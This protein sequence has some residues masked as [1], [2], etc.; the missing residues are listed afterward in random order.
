MLAGSRLRQAA[1]LALAALAVHEARYL[2]AY[3]A[4]AERAETAAGHTYLQLLAPLL[5]AVAAAAIAVTVLAPVVHRRLPRL[6]DPAAATER[7]AGYAVALLAIFACQ[8]LLEGAIAGHDVFAGLTGPGGWLALPLAIAFGALI[9]SAGRW[10]ER[11]E[12]RVATALVR[13]RPRAQAGSARPPTPRLAPLC[14]R[15]LAFGLS[16]RPP[17]LPTV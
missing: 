17:P 11:A 13:S 5:A 10:L 2:L 3:G 7:A 15:P 1:L 6:A 16:R 12:L 14:S 4:H 9:E 8:E